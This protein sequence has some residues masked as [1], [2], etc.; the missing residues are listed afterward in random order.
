VVS[1]QVVEH[2]TPDAGTRVGTP[3]P[4]EANASFA[5]SAIVADPIG[6]PVRVGSFAALGRSRLDAGA[7]YR[8]ALD[9][10]GNLWERPVPRSGV[11]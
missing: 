5:N 7:G 3:A 9:L 4:S 8:G 10:P 1:R 6:G 2:R 11:L